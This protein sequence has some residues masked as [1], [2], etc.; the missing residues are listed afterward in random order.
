MRPTP[1]PDQPCPWCALADLL[2][3]LTAHGPPPPGVPPVP[4]ESR[5]D[6]RCR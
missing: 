1:A 6:T 2:A 3:L 4:S 5:E